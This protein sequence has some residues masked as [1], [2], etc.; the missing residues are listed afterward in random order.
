[1]FFLF[2]LLQSC[3]AFP[4]LGDDE[5]VAKCESELITKGF[6]DNLMQC[7]SIIY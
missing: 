5:S 7:V 4:S 1:M 3:C 2:I 6:D